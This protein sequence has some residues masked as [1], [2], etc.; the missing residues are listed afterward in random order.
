LDGVKDEKF[1]FADPRRF[2]S[3]L[4]PAATVDLESSTSTVRAVAAAEPLALSAETY[5]SF[6]GAR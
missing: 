3:L 1:P 5:A 2:Q 6:Q 4:H